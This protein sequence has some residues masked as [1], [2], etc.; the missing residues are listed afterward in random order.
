MFL[1]LIAIV[2]IVAWTYILFIREW[3]EARYPTSFYTRVIHHTED[4]L[5]ANSRTILV[6]RLYWVG[7]I[8]VALHDLAAQAGLD[9]T[10]L[11]SQVAAFVPPQYQPLALSAFL[12]LTGIAFEWLRRKTT[13]PVLP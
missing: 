2:I 11:V 8:I 12:F 9:W 4:V 7:A 6:S 3:L 10:P 5:W 13:T 1:I